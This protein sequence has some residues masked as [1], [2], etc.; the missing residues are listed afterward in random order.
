MINEFNNKLQ[1][2]TPL[3]VIKNNL[4][5]WLLISDKRLAELDA[6]RSMGAETL[7]RP[8]PGCHWG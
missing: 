2:I 7:L 8:R 1:A 6:S 5:C 3:T 4:G